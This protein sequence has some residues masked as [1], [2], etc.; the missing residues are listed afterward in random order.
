VSVNRTYCSQMSL[1]DSEPQFATASRGTIW[2]LLEHPGPW[3]LEP[4]HDTPLP[5]RA[6]QYLLQLLRTLPSSRLLLIKRAQRVA[7]SFS[8]LVAMACEHEPVIFSFTLSSYDELSN[9]DVAALAVGQSVPTTNR[10]RATFLV[11]TDGKHDACCAKFGL[12]IY[13]AMKA[14]VGD[15][16]WQASHVGGDRFAANIVCFPHGIFY[17][18]V[19]PEDIQ[20][21]VDDY[22]GGH[23]YLPKYRGRSCYPF[24]VQ[25][26]EHFVR[27]KSNISAINELR[28]ERRARVGEQTWQ[29]E[30]RSLADLRMHVVTLWREMSASSRHLSCRAEHA[31]RVPQYHL[32]NYQVMELQSQA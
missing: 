17:G 32:L 7:G 18:R 4:P 25:A 2:L 23:V 16:V 24:V 13:E 11:C 14:H 28:F 27:V 22:G 20:Q 21:L 3:G 26:A 12:S 31:Q 9:I 29:V 8:F 1:Q 15:V 30:F 6:K 5:E 10:E 19:A